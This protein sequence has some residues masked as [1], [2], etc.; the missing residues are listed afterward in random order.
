LRGE[1]PG[2]RGIAAPAASSMMLFHSPQASHLPCQRPWAEPQ[3]WQ[4]KLA[5]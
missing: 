2:S 5:S 1:R 3:L 4:T